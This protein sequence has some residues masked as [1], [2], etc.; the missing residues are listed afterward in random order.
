M[1]AWFQFSRVGMARSTDPKEHLF[2]PLSETDVSSQRLDEDAGLWSWVWFV[3]AFSVVL[4]DRM[5]WE[6]GWALTSAPLQRRPSVQMSQLP[7]TRTG[8]DYV[9]P[10]RSAIIQLLCVLPEFQMTMELAAH[11][12]HWNSKI[13][14]DS[15]CLRSGFFSSSPTST[16]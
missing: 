16:S 2:A 3:L 8:Q 15:K 7:C 1:M 11:R 13:H 9:G 14:Q 4:W 5:S 6:V 10:A 12:Q